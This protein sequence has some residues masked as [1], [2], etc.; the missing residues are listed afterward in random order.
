MNIYLWI[1]VAALLLEFFLHTLSRLLDLKNLRSELPVEFKGYY[2]SDEY[3]RSQEYLRTSTRFSYVTSTFDLFIMLLIIF[4]GLFNTV[5]LWLRSF[6]CSSIITGL[7]FFGLLFFI[8]DILGTPFSLYRT[9]IIEEEFGFVGIELENDSY[10]TA[11]KRI[12]SITNQIVA[13]KTRK[14]VV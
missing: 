8:Q 9:F 4:M 1:I 2:S 7:M 11:K 13:P 6:G 5:D 10:E 12:P 3:V 14:T